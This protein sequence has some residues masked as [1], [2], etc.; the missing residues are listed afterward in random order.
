MW[1]N[2]TMFGFNSRLGIGS[3]ILNY[4]PKCLEGDK[5]MSFKINQVKAGD[6]L[7]RVVT[8]S[9]YNKT[10]PEIRIID[11]EEWK[12]VIPYRSIVNK[13]DIVP[14]KV[15]YIKTTMWDIDPNFEF[16]DDEWKEYFLTPLAP[17]DMLDSFSLWVDNGFDVAMA[18]EDYFIS[19]DE[20]E[21]RQ[22]ELRN[23]IH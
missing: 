14:L 11:G 8:S 2:S 18:T 19:K 4:N 7:W 1:T 13:Y 9:M 20:A 15:S 21:A 23:S 6:T 12:K 10:V 22:A 3:F 17:N 16:N 5:T